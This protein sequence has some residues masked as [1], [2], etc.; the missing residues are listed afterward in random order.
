M[1]GNI[2]YAI[3]GCRED[4]PPTKLKSKMKITLWHDQ[5]SLDPNG[6]V[7]EEEIDSVMNRVE[8]LYQAALLK[9]W[10]EAEVDFRREDTLRDSI[11][12]DGVDWETYDEVVWEASLILS[13]VYEAGEFWN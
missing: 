13:A 5:Y 12:V 7:P 4:E 3:I 1:R 6:T 10:P 8:E 2:L 11:E 9:E